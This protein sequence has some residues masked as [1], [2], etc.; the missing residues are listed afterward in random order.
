LL[1]GVCWLNVP[2]GVGKKGAVAGGHAG[3]ADHGAQLARGGGEA[4]ACRRVGPEPGALLTVATPPLPSR[5]VEGRKR[6]AD[7]CSRAGPPPAR[8]QGAGR[9]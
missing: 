5:N 9:G 1:G 7:H 8:K 4:V 3:G 2:V 6:A